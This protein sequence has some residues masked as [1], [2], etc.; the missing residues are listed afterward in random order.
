[1]PT[2]TIDGILTRYEVAG[3]GPPLLMFSPGGFNA[4][5]DTWRSQGV[6]RRLDL[7]GHLTARYTCITF[8]KRETG[9]SGGRVERIGWRSYALQGKG[10]LDHLGI[11]RAHLMGGC[12][13]CSIVTT[14][15]VAHPERVSS[16]V[17]YSPAGGPRYRMA[18]HARLGRHL[19]FVAEHGLAPVAELARG[20][21]STF[22]QDPRVGPWV[23]VLRRDPDF[24]AAYAR[25]D[26]ERYAVVVTG[27]SRLLF[28]RDT[29]PGPEPEDLM[30]LDLPAL[31]VPGEDSSHA[32]SAARYL[33]ECLPRA[34]YWDAP[35]AEQTAETA[36]KR[37]L[38]FLASPPPRD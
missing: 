1:M 16:M 31:V 3:A 35:V 6:Y 5:L 24:A 27:M 17:L 38:E 4:S 9:Q 34:D 32:T 29:V 10:L 37:I 2:T 15:A 11:E 20:G 13:G 7:L 23:T 12:V 18:Q 30:L 8:D 26:A 28:D 14:L 22:T 33:Q 21:D 25:G 36:P 19:A